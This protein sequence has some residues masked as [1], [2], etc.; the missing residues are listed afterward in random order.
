MTS[1]EL[2]SYA[3]TEPNEPMRRKH[4]LV[5]TNEAWAKQVFNWVREGDD[6]GGEVVDGPVRVI[7]TQRDKG[8]PEEV[9]VTNEFRR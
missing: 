7:R 6:Y 5:T 1:W 9:D 4:L 3:R 8:M 2:Y